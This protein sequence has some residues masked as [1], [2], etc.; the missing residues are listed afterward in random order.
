MS[1]ERLNCFW[2]RLQKNIKWRVRGWGGDFLG[3]RKDGSKSLVEMLVHLLKHTTFLPVWWPHPC[4]PKILPCM[5]IAFPVGRR[6]VSFLG[7]III[8]FLS[9]SLF[10]SCSRKFLLCVTFLTGHPGAGDGRLGKAAPRARH[11]PCFL[12]LWQPMLPPHPGCVQG[13]GSPSLGRGGR[14][15][16]ARG[17]ILRGHPQAGQPSLRCMVAMLDRQTAWM[18][19]PRAGFAEDRA[20]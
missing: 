4:M 7:F 3:C 11:L 17:W 2:G 20:T 13:R 19:L 9:L 5:W 18:T 16:L 6:L 15:V 10:S 14:V 8:F 12:Q 1:T